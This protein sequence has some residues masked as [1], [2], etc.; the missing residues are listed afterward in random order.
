MKLDCASG[1]G[2]IRERRDFTI[3]ARGKVVGGRNVI[4]QTVQGGRL[5]FGRDVMLQTVKSAMGS[6]RRGVML[7]TLEGQRSRSGEV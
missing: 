7:Q 5:S 1:K 3:I 2:V 4:L 6:L